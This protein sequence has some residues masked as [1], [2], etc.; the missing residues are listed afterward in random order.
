MFNMQL[1]LEMFS[2]ICLIIF[3]YLNWKNIELKNIYKKM[4]YPF[5]FFLIFA[6]YFLPILKPT[7]LNINY[8]EFGGFTLLL[9]LIYGILYFK[10]I[11]I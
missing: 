3:N 4:F 6:I 2:A 8:I 1:F 7:N 11:F 10:S 5:S 9:Y